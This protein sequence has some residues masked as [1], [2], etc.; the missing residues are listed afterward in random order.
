MTTNTTHWKWFDSNSG[1]QPVLHNSTQK[2]HVSCW[3]LCVSCFTD[4]FST[5]FTFACK[6]ASY[7]KLKTQVQSMQQIHP[8]PKSASLKFQNTQKQ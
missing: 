1:N 6:A 8:L 4:P 3:R 2:E 5:S 7:M